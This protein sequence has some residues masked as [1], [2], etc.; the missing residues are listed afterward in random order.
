MLESPLSDFTDCSP[1]THLTASTILLLPLPF[2]PTIHVVLPSKEIVS[3]SAKDLNP[4]A[5]ISFKYILSHLT[6]IE[7]LYYKF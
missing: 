4:V 2:G 3:L 5:L 7:K 1:R 6:H